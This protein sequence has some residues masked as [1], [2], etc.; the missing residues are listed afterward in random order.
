MTELQKI[1]IR[2]NPW[3]VPSVEEAM[4]GWLEGGASESE[5]CDA[6]AKEQQARAV[7]KPNDEGMRL[8]DQI[9]DFIGTRVQIQFWDSNMI[10]CEEEGPFP[11]EGDCNDVLVLK[12]G[13]F[14]QAFILLDKVR[15]IPTPDGC[16]PLG[17]LIAVDGISGQLAPLA[18]V[19]EIWPVNPDG[20]VTAEIEQNRIMAVQSHNSIM[21]G[22]R[23]LVNESMTIADIDVLYPI[24]STEIQKKTKAK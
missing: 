6:R 17:C 24:W 5:I 23:K 10:M 14:I 8:V 2:K 3:H 4:N 15:V 19:Y 9:K 20:S 18:D 7:W 12:H 11:L 13:E 22:L 21:H 16:T 1:T